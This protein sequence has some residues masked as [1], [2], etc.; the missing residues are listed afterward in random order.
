[1]LTHM[2]ELGLRQNTKK[3][4][5]SPLQWT[6]FLGVVWDSTSMQARLSPASCRVIL[7]AVKRIMLGQSLTVKQFQRLLGLMVLASNMIPFGT[8]VHETSTVVA[9]DQRFFSEGQP[10]LH[11]Q[12]HVAMLLCLGNMEETLVPVPGSRAGSFMSSQDANDRCLSHRL[13]SDPRGTL[14]SRS[15]E[16]LA[17]YIPGAHNIGADIL[18]RQGLRPGGWRHEWISRGVSLSTLVLA[19]ASS[20]SRT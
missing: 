1:M 3:S 2:K 13:G 14:E 11:D 17:A 6:T 18:S 16:G 5:I 15:V 7:S 9:Q 20:S 8:T 12:G 10:L 19:H 4:V